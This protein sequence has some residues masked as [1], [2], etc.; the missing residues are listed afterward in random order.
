MNVNVVYIRREIRVVAG[1]F[2]VQ[3]CC[4]EVCKYLSCCVEQINLLVSS[5]ACHFSPSRKIASRK[6]AARR[7]LTPGTLSH[8]P[9]CSTLEIDPPL[10]LRTRSYGGTC[11][12]SRARKPC[13]TPRGYAG[14]QSTRNVHA[15]AVHDVYPSSLYG[16]YRAYFVYETVGWVAYLWP[17]LKGVGLWTVHLAC[18]VH[19]M[20]LT[21]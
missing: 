5:S 21:S 7:F 12:L 13:N 2:P 3:L 19:P 11:V 9:Q 16:P 14:S 8:V 17:L 6:H 20:M 18:L 10:L 15:R 1:L 4:C